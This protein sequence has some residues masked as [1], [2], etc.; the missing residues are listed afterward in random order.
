MSGNH[1]SHNYFTGLPEISTILCTDSS[2]NPT[3]VEYKYGQGRVVATGQPLEAAWSWSMDT[4]PIYPNM[5]LYTFNK[6]IPEV[7]ELA[8][9]GV[10]YDGDLTLSSGGEVL[11]SV[12]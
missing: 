5:I 7:P 3:L 12:A 2:Q 10:V 11:S 1:A 8:A 9:S 6:E 4:K